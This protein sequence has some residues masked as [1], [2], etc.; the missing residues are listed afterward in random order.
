MLRIIGKSGF[1]ISDTGIGLRAARCERETVEKS[2]CCEGSAFCLVR[3]GCLASTLRG[4][5][6][7]SDEADETDRPE[8]GTAL[9]ATSEAECGIPR[10]TLLSFESGFP[11]S[12]ADGARAGP[13]HGPIR[14]IRLI[15]CIR[16][17]LSV[18]AHLA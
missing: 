9:R 11:Q 14:C 7:F 10:G 13:V 6:D 17:T 8:T 18:D 3:F 2:S 12:V 16:I 5:A 15:R 4:Y 1:G